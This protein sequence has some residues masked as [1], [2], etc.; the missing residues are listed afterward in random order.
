[1]NFRGALNV[2][3]VDNFNAYI[4]LEVPLIFASSFQFGLGGAGGL[5]YEVRRWFDPFFEVGVRHLLT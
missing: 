2:P 5:E 4:S 3:V 1:M